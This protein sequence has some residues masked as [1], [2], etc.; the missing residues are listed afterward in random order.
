MGQQVTRT[1]DMSDIIQ[2]VEHISLDAKSYKQHLDN[3]TLDEYYN[4]IIRQVITDMSTIPM[5]REFEGL[6]PIATSEEVNDGLHEV[7]TILAP[8][9]SKPNESVIT[10][11]V[12]CMGT[13]PV[14]DLRAALYLKNKNKL[15]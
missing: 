14:H 9:F 13:F 4:E 10:D 11:L 1:L 8:M 12:T 3:N 6:E 7:V 2:R 15:N 5:Y